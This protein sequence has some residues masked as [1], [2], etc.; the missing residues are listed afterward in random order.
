[1]EMMARRDP[2]F[3][4]RALK[5]C[6]DDE[7]LALMTPEEHKAWLESKVNGKL[8]F[9]VN[10]YSVLEKDPLP[11]LARQYIAG[12]TPFL[13]V[14]LHI[15][16]KRMNG[17]QSKMDLVDRESMKQ[18]RVC[19]S[20]LYDPRVKCEYPAQAP[21]AFRNLPLEESQEDDFDCAKHICTL[22]GF[23]S[24]WA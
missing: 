11:D 15:Y 24:G 4:V 22:N 10:G 7:G 21:T 18:A 20:P 13:S 2:R 17:N 12:D 19:W 3:S 9:A 8:Y 16:A 14:L 5:C 23:E 1:M 6:M